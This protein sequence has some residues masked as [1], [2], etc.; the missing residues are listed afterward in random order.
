MDVLLNIEMKRLARK[1]S[2]RYFWMFWLRSWRG[3]SIE[4]QWLAKIMHI[5]I[6]YL[7]S[8]LDSHKKGYLTLEDL[9]KFSSASKAVKPGNEEYL[10]LM[11][12]LKGNLG[13]EMVGC[14]FRI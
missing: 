7:F 3:G 12:K 10:L 14:I 5:P 8:L 2:E 6:Y 13:R 11:K 9:L 1:Q 4:S